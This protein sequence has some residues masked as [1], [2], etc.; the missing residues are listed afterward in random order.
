MFLTLLLNAILVVPTVSFMGAHGAAI[1][2]FSTELFA[3][4][5]LINY[6]RQQKLLEAYSESNRVLN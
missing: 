2:T 4:I 6:V 1:A 5:Y 3:A